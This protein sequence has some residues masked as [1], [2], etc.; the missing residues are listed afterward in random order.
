MTRQPELKP[1][2]GVRFDCCK[3]YYRLY[4]NKAKTAYEGRCPRCLQPV[5]IRIGPGGST[6]R[7]FIVR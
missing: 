6:S 3:V 4:R 5:R 1:F 7:M 2:I